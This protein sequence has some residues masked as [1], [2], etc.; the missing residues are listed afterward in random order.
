MDWKFLRSDSCGSSTQQVRVKHRDSDNG[1]DGVLG[2]ILGV[3]LIPIV[4]VALWV[5]IVFNNSYRTCV[6]LENGANLGYE[7]V[8]DL[9]RPYLKPIAVPRLEDGTPLIHD[10][11]WSIKITPTTIHGLSMA[12]AIDERGYHFAWRNDVGLVLEAENPIDYERLVA[13]AGHANWDIEINNIGTGAL[14]NRLIERPES[15][16]GR[17]PTSLITW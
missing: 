10:S 12:S 1:N 5:V 6:R 11:L 14:M 7:A 17:C 15:D 13:E 3:A 9:S 2:A 8:F 4:L 16:V